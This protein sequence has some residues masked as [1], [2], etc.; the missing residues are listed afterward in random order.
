MRVRPI[1]LAAV[2]LALALS[3]RTVAAQAP[4]SWLGTWK[5]NIARSVYSPGPPPY[6]RATYTI[7]PWDD[8]WKVTYEMVHPRGGVTHLEW[9]GRLDG[10]DYPLQGLDEVMT[11]SYTPAPDGAYDVAVKI[12]GRL[13]GRARITL[14]ADGLTMTT[15]TVGRNSSGQPVTTTTVYEKVDRIR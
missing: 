6:K 13:T 14:S 2:V 7:E 4:A 10:R 1:G 5:L 3:P 11:Y 9:T 8:G 15:T 12:D